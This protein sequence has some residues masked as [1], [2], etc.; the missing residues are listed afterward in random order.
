MGTLLLTGCSW[1]EESGAD[2]SVSS[3]KLVRQELTILMPTDSWASTK[4][5]IDTFE[6]HVRL[7]EAANPGVHVTV[8]KLPTPQGYDR[9]IIARLSESRPADLIFGEFYSV[10]ARNMALTDLAPFL[11]GDQLTTEDLNKPLTD[12]STVEGKL[13]GI[14][15]APQPLAVFYNRRVSAKPCYLRM[16]VKRTVI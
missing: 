16:A 9:A 14:P 8:E 3:T 5:R 10:L 4:Y 2:P 12:L 13:L 15:L 1:L 7:F 11:K 6:K